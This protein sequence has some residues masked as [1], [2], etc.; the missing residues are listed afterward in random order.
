MADVSALDA[1]EAVGDRR[2]AQRAHL[3]AGDLADDIDVVRSLVEDG[4]VGVDQFG[5]EPGPMVELVEVPAVDRAQRAELARF[6]EGL[7]LLDRRVETMRM[8]REQLDA[9]FRG[10]L[11]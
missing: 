1:G 10:D 6:D 4:T 2:A 3:T 7:N 8:T 11:P 9:G 5:A